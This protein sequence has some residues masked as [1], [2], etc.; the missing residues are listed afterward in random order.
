[1][2]VFILFA[3]LFFV[4]A[5]FSAEFI[6]PGL[7]HN[8]AELDFIKAKVQAEEEP[9][10]SGWKKLLDA[11][12]SDMDWESGAIENVLRGGYNKPDIG[13]SDL[14]R[15]AS[16]AYSQ[17]IQWIVTGDTIHASKA[18]EILNDWGSTLKSIGEHDAKLLVGM[19]GANMINGAEIIRHTSSLWS[20]AEIK[21]FEQMLLNVHYEV[22]KDFFPAAN[23]NWDTSMIQTMLSIGIFLDNDTI[24][25]KAVNYFLEGEGNG[26]IGYYINDFGECQESGRDQS[27][28]QMGLGFLG[29]ACEIAWKQGVDLYGALDNRLALGFEYTAKYNLGYDVPYETYTSIDGKYVNKS[30]SSRGRGRFRPIYERIYHHYHDRMKMEMPYTLEAIG[31]SRPEGWHIQHTSWGTLLYADLPNNPKGYTPN[32]PKSLERVP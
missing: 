12:V 31:K 32:S 21:Q 8:K 28:T 25:Q 4:P 15:D 6:H 11:D 29:T 23:G 20:E 18:I 30:I 13:A 9:W 7:L 19:S 17:A 27:H 2:K 5:L 14:E 22:I 16:A 1:M 10:I 3:Q 26:A 24:F